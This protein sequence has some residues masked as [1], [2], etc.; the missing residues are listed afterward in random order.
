MLNSA[1]G[2]TLPT[3]TAPPMI[4][5]PFNHST[6]SGNRLTRMAILVILPVATSII[7]PFFWARIASAIASTAFLPLGLSS[8]SNSGRRVVPSSPD[9]PWI[10]AA[11]KCSRISPLV[12]P[13]C[14]TISVLFRARR[15]RRQF[16]VTLS[17]EAFPWTVLTPVLAAF[18]RVESASQFEVRRVSGEKKCE[19]LRVKLF[20][21]IGNIHRHVLD[22]SRPIRGFSSSFLQRPERRGSG[23]PST[24][25]RHHV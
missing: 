25:D 14:T 17:K 10:F 9:F 19:R 5:T 3:L 6:T 24:D 16:K 2:V 1:T 23:E 15:I 18:N 20:G 4:T 13:A 21:G 8:G 11:L 7:S 12:S 22:H